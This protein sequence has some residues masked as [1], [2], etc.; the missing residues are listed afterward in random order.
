MPRFLK[1]IIFI[2]LYSRFLILYSSPLN[3]ISRFDT[4]YNIS[5]TI[6]NSG[7]TYVTYDIL[8]TN[9][10]TSVYSTQ[11]S[12]G[13]NH[14]D[15]QSVIV[16]DEGSRLTPEIM[17]T[18]NLTNITFDFKNKVVGKDKLHHFTISFKTKDIATKTGAVWEV[19]IPKLTS[20][21]GISDVNVKLTT[22]VGFK[23]PAYISPKPFKTDKNN[24]YFNSSS[25]GNKSISAVFGTTQYFKFTLFYNLTNDLESKAS[26]TITLPPDTPYQQMYYEQIT[27]APASVATDVDGNWIA[28]VILP[29]KTTTQV[30]AEGYTRISLTPEKRPLP[31]PDLYTRGNDIWPTNN[32]EI[33]ATATKINSPEA[34]YQYVVDLLDYD[35]KRLDEDPIREGATFAIKYPDRAICTDFTD[36]FVAY[37][38]TNKIPSRE[39]EG[40]AFSNNERLRPLSLSRDVLHAWPEYYDSALET[41][42]QIDPTWANT[43][44]GIDYFHKMDLNHFVFVI[45]GVNPKN[46]PPAGAYKTAS[47]NSK[48]VY[49]EPSLPVIF[50][51]PEIKAEIQSVNNKTIVLEITNVSGLGLNLPAHLSDELIPLNFDTSIIMP[52]F[53]NQI[54]EL[55]IPNNTLAWRSRQSTIILNVSDQSINLPITYESS[56][57]P[58]VLYTTSAVLVVT[59]ALLAGYLHLRKQRQ[60]APLHW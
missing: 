5:Y 6:D 15:I 43:T 33:L 60:S 4:K 21:D 59:V 9:N 35:Y 46:P 7:L 3:A 18:D 34:I 52:A 37:A 27:P 20:S 42:I 16:T 45:H 57:L 23:E 55:P 1:I 36:L 17:T 32:P 39:L 56:L 38:R 8:Q 11:F 48:D 19:N 31:D 13:L 44:L 30:K 51:E 22:P 50:P 29:E 24:Y 40:F 14:T 58:L 41:W 28:T 49:V 54:I 10:L 12:L 26:T 2:L 53:G 47:S 25:L